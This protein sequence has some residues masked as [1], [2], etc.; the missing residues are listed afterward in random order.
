MVSPSVYNLQGVFKW[1]L[2]YLVKNQHFVG[3]PHQVSSSLHTC[4]VVTEEWSVSIKWKMMQF[5]IVL[6]AQETHDLVNLNIKIYLTLLYISSNTFREVTCSVWVIFFLW[7]K[8]KS[9][10]KW[11]EHVCSC[12]NKQLCTEALIL[13]KC[14][15]I[16]VN[17]EGPKICHNLTDPEGTLPAS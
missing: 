8:D 14:L 2:Q 16:E 11:I 12:V 7:Q 13:L 6:Y 3:V 1:K 5:L 4:T 10:S 9:P 15:I 17:T